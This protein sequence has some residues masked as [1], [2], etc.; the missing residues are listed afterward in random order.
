MS[1][2]N[3]NRI[4]NDQIPEASFLQEDTF[5]ASET[6]TIGQASRVV[7]TTADASSI[8]QLPSAFL[9]KGD[10]IRIS[11]VITGSGTIT[12]QDVAGNAGGANDE[13]SETVSLDT[14]LD[15]VIVWSDGF[16]W[17]VIASEMA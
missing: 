17:N 9:R 13:L 4:V 16:V 3:Q 8:Y 11:T 10:T 12:V 6:L 2:I 15:Y 5:G 14:T 7:G 1:R